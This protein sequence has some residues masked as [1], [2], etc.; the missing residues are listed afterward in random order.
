MD[1]QKCSL[2]APFREDTALEEPEASACL[3]NLTR[4][5][6]VFRRIR[7]GNPIS[8]VLLQLVTYQIYSAEAIENVRTK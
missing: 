1:P 2:G 5:V 6:V 8:G 3:V 7:G 4:N